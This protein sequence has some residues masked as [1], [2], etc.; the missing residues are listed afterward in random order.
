MRPRLRSDF[1]RF[2]P[3]GQIRIPLGVRSNG[4]PITR[5]FQLYVASDY[6]PAERTPAWDELYVKQSEFAEPPCPAKD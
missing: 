1:G 3:A 6:A 5:V 4:C 2:E